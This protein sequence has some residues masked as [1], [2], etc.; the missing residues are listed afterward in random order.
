VLVHAFSGVRQP[1][2]ATK[3]C[4]AGDYCRR[5]VGFLAP[6]S[7]MRLPAATKS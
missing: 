4:L 1:A 5:A 7:E 6:C 3:V 2:A